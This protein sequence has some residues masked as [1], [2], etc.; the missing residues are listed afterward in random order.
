MY[1]RYISMRITPDAETGPNG[2]NQ[3]EAELGEAT[4]GPYDLPE[5]RTLVA[6]DVRPASLAEKAYYLIRDRIVAIDLAPGSTIDEKALMAELGLGRTPIREALRRL[7]DEGLVEVVPRR[8]MF[9]TNI[10]IRDLAAI[11][12]LRVIVEGHAARL[13]AERAS[14]AE[15]EHAGELLRVV[16]RNDD[17]DQRSLMQVDQLV[18]RHIHRASHNAYLI[19]VAEDHFLLS[20]RLWFLAIDRIPRLP[21]AVAEHHHLLEAV[22]DGDADAAEDIARTHVEGFERA[23]REVI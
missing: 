20:L 10:D 12:E 19:R 7:A 13:A 9:V 23:I 6:G 4:S 22:R 8:G 5:L 18:H 14:A 1:L 16:A 11:S 21:Q 17:A 3:A 15:R 2:Q